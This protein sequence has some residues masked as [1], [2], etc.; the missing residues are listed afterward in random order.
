[1]RRDLSW[2]LNTSNLAS[3]R[4]LED[5]PEV[6]RSTV[7]FGIPDLA[8]KTASSLDTAAVTKLLKRAILQF[9]PRLLKNSVKVRLVVDHD[10]HTPN[11]VCFAI[12]A[13]LWSQPLPLKLYFRTDLDLEDGEAKITEVAAG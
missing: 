4:D 2:L 7:N 8:G 13:D 5:Y 10:Q 1:V 12:E 11:A 6:E 9:E 3:V